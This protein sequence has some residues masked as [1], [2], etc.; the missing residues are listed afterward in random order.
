MKKYF[1][2]FILLSFIL[3]NLNA[4]EKILTR[5]SNT[6][7]G[8][9]KFKKVENFRILVILNDKKYYLAPVVKVREIGK[10]GYKSLSSKTLKKL[11]ETP[12]MVIAKLR[13]VDKKKKI[14]E[15]YEITIYPH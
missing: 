5:E 14:K 12:Q 11:L 10:R 2:I 13:D 8:I 1:L 4:Q 9:I 7:T 15:I 3:V 6:I